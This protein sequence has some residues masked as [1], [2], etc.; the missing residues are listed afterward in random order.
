M[1]RVYFIKNKKGRLTVDLRDNEKRVRIATP[2][3][4]CTDKAK[5]EYRRLFYYEFDKESDNTIEAAERAAKRA[6]DRVMK[7]IGENFAIPEGQK[8]K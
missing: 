2:L 7:I 5:Y 8:N 1:I 4:Y 3:Y 6:N